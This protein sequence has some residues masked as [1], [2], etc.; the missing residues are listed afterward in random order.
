MDI[1]R[2]ALRQACRAQRGNI[3]SRDF[4]GRGELAIAQIVKERQELVPDRLRRG[5]GDLL[6]DYTAR[7]AVEGV[8]FFC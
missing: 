3:D 6:P 2:L 8:D 5:A 4:L 1:L 7:Q